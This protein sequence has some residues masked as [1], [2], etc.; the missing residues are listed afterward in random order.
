MQTRAAKRIRTVSPQPEAAGR[1]PV[2]SV[3]ASANAV[4]ARLA[5]AHDRQILETWEP[6]IAL[7]R[8]W[9]V[10]GGCQGE[11][12]SPSSPSPSASP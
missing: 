2:D 6:L 4:S 9:V 10:A 3:E 7:Y 12:R 1:R 8:L 5:A 11:A